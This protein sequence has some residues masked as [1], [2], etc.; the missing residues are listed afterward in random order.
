MQAKVI[1]SLGCAADVITV[2]HNPA[3]N[4]ISTD[5]S[6]VLPTSHN[7]RLSVVS[8]LFCLHM[9]M[10]MTQ[11]VQFCLFGKILSCHIEH[12]MSNVLHRE[13][14]RII[15]RTEITLLLK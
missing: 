3:I 11:S 5:H 13:H 14:H 12:F 15:L 4:P 8:R 2:G 1:Q 7:N 10:C 9:F 6:I